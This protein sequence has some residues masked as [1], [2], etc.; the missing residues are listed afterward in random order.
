MQDTSHITVA[1]QEVSTPVVKTEVKEASTE[2]KETSAASQEQATKEASDT[3]SESDNDEDTAEGE[4]LE[5]SA[6]KPKQ[7]NGYQK[8]IDKLRARLTQAE[9]RALEAE[10]RANAKEQE[11]LAQTQDTKATETKSADGRPNPDN[12]ETNAEYIDALTDWKLDQKEKQRAEKEEKQKITQTYE[13]LGKS[14]NESVEAFK[15]KTKD[16]A[17][18]WEDVAHVKVSPIVESEILHSELKAE[19]AY[20]IAK[21][22]AEFERINSLPATQA[23]KAIGIIEDRL[24]RSKSEEKPKPEAKKQT[25]AP[26]PLA[27]V[28][29]NTSVA[30]SLH[31]MDP[32]EYIKARQAELRKK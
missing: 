4:E 17:D 10:A 6:D 25:K 27:S 2:V 30:K 28:S 29:G 15:A 24:K 20:E 1:S 22:P 3:S 31:D 32:D 21:N 7:K 16:W 18:V 5:A 14:Y 19:L 8:R 9:Q 11:R 26:P 23:I 13:Q 12:F